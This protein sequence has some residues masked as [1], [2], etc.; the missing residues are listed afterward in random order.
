MKSKVKIL[1]LMQKQKNLDIQE[2]EEESE[3]DDETK[4]NKDL[5][6]IADNIPDP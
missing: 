5:F 3:I 6:Q 4:R 2:D 1:E